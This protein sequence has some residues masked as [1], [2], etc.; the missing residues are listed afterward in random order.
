M[1][2]TCGAADREIVSLW[3]VTYMSCLGMEH[4]SLQL[5]L[6]VSIQY[7]LVLYKILPHTI[8]QISNSFPIVIA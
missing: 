7:E 2:T 4:D 8:F 1:P 6:P 3:N 5:S